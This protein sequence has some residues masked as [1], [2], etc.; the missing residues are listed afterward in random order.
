MN[1]LGLT[2]SHLDSLGLTWTHSHLDPLGLTSS[3]MG[4]GKASQGETEKG[5][6]GHLCSLV[7]TWTH[8]VSLGLTGTHMD[9]LELTRERERIS[10]PK[11]KGK[12]GSL[13]LSD[14]HKASRPRESTHVSTARH[15]AIS[16]LDSPP[17][18]STPTSP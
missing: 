13:N 7:L 5:R 2:W 3:H 16:R 9:S 12:G 17:Q 8:L 15:G 11:G 18:P 14:S 1:S 6:M 10:G 4:K